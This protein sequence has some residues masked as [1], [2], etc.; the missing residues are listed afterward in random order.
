[1]HGS[2]LSDRDAL[3][4]RLRRRP[5]VEG[6]NLVAVDAAD[7]LILDEAEADLSVARA[8]TVAVIG[9][10]YG[11]LTLGAAAA[12]GVTGIR[13]HQ[14]PLTGELALAANA[15]TTGLSD[16]YRSCALGEE[17]LGG[18]TVV[19]MQLPR[20]LS[21]LTEIAENIARYADPSVVVYAGGRDK[22]ISTAMNDVLGRS[23]SAVRASLGRQKSRV[24]TA[25]GP[26]AP[27]EQT[28]PVT[29]HLADIGLDVVSYGAAF[30]GAKLDIGTRYLLDFLPRVNP[31]ARTAV[32]LGCGTGILAVSLA[33]LLPDVSVIA[34]DQSS[35]A[36]A[37]AAATA[38][39]NGF[40]D[41]VST[42]RDD[43][44]STLGTDSQD[45]VLCNPPFHVGAAVHTGGASKMFAEAGR[46]LRPGG[47]LWT[48]YNSHLGYRGRLQRLVGTTDVVG[49]NPK[50]TVTRSVA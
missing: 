10:H 6:P 39:A 13:V 32:D 21:E 16:R 33:R 26:A 7:R 46:V 42:L 41:R 12:H 11:A 49:R 25:S 8:G 48:V 14:D 28:Y 35:A 37:S 15:E 9:D 36:V 44:M 3:F 31:R 40:G 4:A 17:L 47:E 1:M 38:R 5:D 34:T 50:F 43:A 22:H 23:F 27:A 30:A 20:S 19:L 18:A 2:E 24:L 45:V 29:D